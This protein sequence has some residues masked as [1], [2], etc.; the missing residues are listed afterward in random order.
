MSPDE[1]RRAARAALMAA[2]VPTPSA[3]K[4]KPFLFRRSSAAGNEWRFTPLPHVTTLDEKGR[5]VPFYRFTLAFKAGIGWG[6]F[7]EMRSTNLGDIPAG[8]DPW[9]E[10]GGDWFPTLP[11]AVAYLR[12]VLKKLETDHA[13]EGVDI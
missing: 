6:A 11:E 7:H 13:G 2:R 3:A 8:W 4:T 12:G 10:C 1:I 9:H 5:D